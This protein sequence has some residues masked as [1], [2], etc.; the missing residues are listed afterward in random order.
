MNDKELTQIAKHPELL[1]RD[2]KLL[3]MARKIGV[4]VLAIVSVVTKVERN[5]PTAVLTLPVVRL[6]SALSSS[7]VLPPA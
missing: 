2:R 3:P 6:K 7:A 5:S 1:G 4:V